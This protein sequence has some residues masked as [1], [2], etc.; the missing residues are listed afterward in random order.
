MSEKA[1]ILLFIGLVLLGQSS[2]GQVNRYIVHLTDKANSSYSIDRPEEFL[3]ERAIERREQ[4]GIPILEQDLPVNQSYISQIKDLGVDVYFKTKWF[5]AV[6]VQ[7]DE[8]FISQIEQFGFVNDVVYVAPGS[9]LI[10]SP[11]GSSQKS[12]SKRTKRVKQEASEVQNNM[13]GIDALHESGYTG[14]GILIA[15]MDGG[16]YGMEDLEPFDH[17]Y[18]AGTLIH[19]Y[20]YIAGREYVYDYSNH[21]T[22][23]LSLMA[24][25]EPGVFVGSAYDSD[26]MLFVTE[27]DCFD[28]EHRIEEYNWVFAA[29]FADSAGV[30]VINTSLG[31][32]EFEDPSM[33]YVQEDM[34]GNTAIISRANDIAFSKGIIVVASAGNEGNNSWGTITAP[35]DANGIL[36]VGNITQDGSRAS[37][38]SVGPSADDRIKPEVVAL[39]S[40]VQVLSSSGLIVPGNGTSFSSPQVA[41][42]SALLWQAYPE[43]S[44]EELRFLLMETS[45]NSALPNNQIGYGIPN[46]NSFYNFLSFSDSDEKYILYPNPADT[47]K[48]IIRANNPAETPSVNVKIF[49]LEGK[50]LMEEEVEFSWQDNTRIIDIYSLSV[51]VYIFNLTSGEEVEKYRIVK[52]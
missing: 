38:S 33:S 51:G 40:S 12:R 35:A 34:D 49:D 21:G 28:C 3:S 39:G 16:F 11:E 43:L 6:L 23:V 14:E 25:Y 45:S 24:A 15:V 22:K 19:T 13:L 31:Y 5:N 30:D 48:V 4:Q 29:E 32:N 36:S 20:D 8:S 26:Y 47:D 18:D 7:C 2:Y 42:L 50:Q 1:S 9:K 44:A 52:I 17:L 41:G 10:N 46:Y 37:T 27:D